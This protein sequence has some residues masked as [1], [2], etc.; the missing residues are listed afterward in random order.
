MFLTLFVVGVVGFTLMALLGFVHG[1]H[2]QG[3]GH[4]GTHSVGGHGHSSLGHGGHSVG[5]HTSHVLQAGH[6]H[7]AKPVNTAHGESPAASARIRSFALIFVSP[8]D[9][10]SFCMGAGLVGLLLPPIF[11]QTTVICLAVV[12]ALLFDF[13]ITR[14]IM[15]LMFAFA[16]KPSEGLEGMIAQSAV[17]ETAFDH[18]GKGLIK[19]VLDGQTVQILAR[20]DPTELSQGVHIAKGETVVILEVDAKRNIC[21]VTRELA[22]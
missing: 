21:R 5:G 16:A 3:G 12:G 2:P 9:L 4:G 6:G 1:G 7:N 8:L 11:T 10:F 20:L 13:G 14:Q 22:G 19:L 18:E 17:A 15:R